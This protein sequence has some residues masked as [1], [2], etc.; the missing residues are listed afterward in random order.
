MSTPKETIEK[1]YGNIPREVGL[2]VIDWWPTPRGIKYYWL[3]LI[4]KFTR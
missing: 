1:A 3:L 2:T 4:R